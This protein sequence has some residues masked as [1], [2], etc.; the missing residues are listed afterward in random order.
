MA[1]GFDQRGQLVERQLN[2]VRIYQT[3]TRP[4]LDQKQLEEAQALLASLPVTHVP[5]PSGLPAGSRMTLPHN[6]FFVGRAPDLLRMAEALKRGRWVGVG[7][8]IAATGLGG[9]GKTQLALSS[10]TGTGATSPVG[11]TG[12]ASVSPRRSRARWSPVVEAWSCVRTL[13]RL[14]W[15]SSW[16]SS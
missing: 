9:L 6:D 5:E 8:L 15:R 13:P 10:Y 12:S 2:V 4:P 7:E 3:A 1:K 11:S 14:S 16:P